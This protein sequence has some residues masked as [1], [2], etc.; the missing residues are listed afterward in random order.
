VAFLR[1]QWLLTNAAKAI[2]ISPSYII[3]SWA[4]IMKAISQTSANITNAA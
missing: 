2:Q 4:V 1:Q 3:V